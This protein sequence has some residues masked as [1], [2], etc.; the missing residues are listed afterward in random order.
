[1][2]ATACLIV[3]ALALVSP[4]E[5][6][7]KG[8]H[9]SGLW[10]GLGLGYGSFG[11]L[12][13]CDDRINGVS[14]FGQIG[15]T[16][17]PSFRLG[18]GMTGFYRSEDGATLTANTGLFITQWFPAASDFF[19]Q[20]GAGFA[21]AELE[22]PLGEVNVRDRESGAGFMIGLGY[23]I[24]PRRVEEGRSRP[25][26]GVEHHDHRGNDRLVPDRARVL[27][28]LIR[29]RAQPCGTRRSRGSHRPVVAM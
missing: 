18:G 11:C 24:K 9:R 12:S 6:Q 4:L 10:G 5:A 26:S 8:A 20:G 17:S 1:M 2:K 7:Q 16:L 13:G 22:I 21:T 23:N 27:L 14:G 3:A 29:L 28:E 25:V 15:G 19:V